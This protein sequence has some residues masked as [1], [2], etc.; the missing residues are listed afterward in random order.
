MHTYIESLITKRKPIFE[1]MERYAEE[2]GVP[3]MELTGIET[4]LQILRIQR[5][6]KILEIGAAIGYSAMRIADALPNSYLVTIE[7]DENRFKQAM[8]NIER[9]GMIGQINVVQGDALEVFE[10]IKNEGPFDAIFVDAAKGQY[11]KFFEM[12]SPLLSE[13]GIILTDN[14]LFKGLVAEDNIESKR[15]RNLVKKIKNYNE[16]LMSHSQ[17]ITTII[18][19]GDGLAVSKKSSI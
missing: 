12:Y 18:P 14:V 7:R 13:N 9:A 16:W 4:L 10:K 3:I 6:A 17:Y 1:E 11:L 5:P 19:V 2:H 8:K 15:I